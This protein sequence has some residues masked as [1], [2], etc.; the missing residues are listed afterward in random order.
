MRSDL[1]NKRYRQYLLRPLIALALC[2]ITFGQSHGQPT[3]TEADIRVALIHR[4]LLFTSWQNTFTDNAKICTLGDGPSIRSFHALKQIRIQQQREVDIENYDPLEH[5]SC[6]ALIV[7]SNFDISTYTLPK[8]SFVICNECDNSD[9]AAINLVRID[10]QI[11][12]N[13]N[14]NAALASGVRFRSDVLKWANDV[15]SDQ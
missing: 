15:R 7:D 2:L 6:M 3:A 10:N 8:A 9:S 12:Y 1:A 14:Q 4:I 13:V 5:A 11:R